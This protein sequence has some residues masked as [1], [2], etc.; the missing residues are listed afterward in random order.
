MRAKLNGAVCLLGSATP[1]LESFF[2]AQEGKY[3]LLQLTERVDA[4]KLPHIDIVDLRIEAAKQRTLPALSGKLVRAMQDRFEKREQ[5]ILFINRRGYSSSMLCTKCGH[6]EECVHCSVAMTYHRA[7]EVLRCHFCGGRAAGAA[8]LP[9][10]RRA[11]HPLAR[12]R[13]AARGGGGEARAARARIERMDADTMTKKNRFR[14]VHAAVRAGKIDVLVGT[15]MIGKGLDFP[16]VTLVGLIDADISM[17]NPG[18]SRATPADL[19]SAAGARCGPR[20]GA[21]DRAGERA[22]RADVHRRRRRRSSFRGARTSPAS[23]R[24]N[25]RCER[26]FTT[27]RSGTSSTT[28]F[29]GRNPGQTSSSSPSSGPSWWQKTLRERGGSCV[30]RR[31][32]RSRRSMT[33]IAGSCCGISPNAVDEGR[34]RPSRN[35]APIFAWPDDITHR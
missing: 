9:E 15:Q 27:R 4:R 8:A 26:V 20:A 19:S 12:A 25:W 28:C 14:E 2:N 10:V 34:A 32:R 21:D 3:R 23:R 17:H 30:G 7:D 35:S 33:S 16:N 5:T 29:A 24:A 13:H 6:V 31:R 18:F 11:R 22:M 1:S